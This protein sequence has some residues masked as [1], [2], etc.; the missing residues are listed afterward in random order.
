MSVLCDAFRTRS[1]SAWRLIKRGQS[2]GVRA[3]EETIT[4]LILIELSHLKR[5]AL[6]VR[7]F[8]KVKEAASGADWEMWLGGGLGTWLGLRIQAKAVDLGSSAFPHLH[9][10]TKGAPLFQSDTLIRRALT[11]SPPRLPAY[12][13]YASA[14]RGVL[15]GWP[16]GSFQRDS[17]LFGCS[18]VSA[19]QVTALRA[20]GSKRSLSD[21]TPHM[22]PWHCLVCCHAFPGSSLPERAAAYLASTLI[23]GD[24]QA[25][26]LDVAEA[27]ATGD[28]DILDGVRWYRQPRPS[29]RVPSYVTTLLEEGEPELPEDI[30]GVLVVRENEETA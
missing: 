22:R 18:L 9:Y 21:L 25:S 14:P 1:R 15:T 12:V 13:L 28:G 10:K 6:F 3:A 7:A 27:G 11:A 26:L 17:R 19:F 4:N 23:A 16:C 24:A 8:S 29:Q 2:A 20:A 5:P 30:A